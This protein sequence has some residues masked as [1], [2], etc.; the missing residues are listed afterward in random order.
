MKRKALVLAIV[1][2]IALL[3]VTPS[4]AAG[5]HNGQGQRYG[6]INRHQRGGGGGGGHDETSFRLYGTI[7]SLDGD[8]KTIVV[9]VE[10]PLKYEGDYITVQTTDSTRF[11][12]CDQTGDEP[13]SYRIEFDD[14]D[15]GSY[16]RISGTV[17]EDGTFVAESVIQYIYP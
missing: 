3:V 4:L 7:E 11:K 14:L 6:A 5:P 12:E 9:L 2:L 13:I 1:V 10:M 8:A 15:E 17:N 16:V